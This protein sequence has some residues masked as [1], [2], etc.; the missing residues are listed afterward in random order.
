[1]TDHKFQVTERTEPT[2][3]IEGKE[4]RSCEV[5][6]ERQIK[7]LPA[8]GHQFSKWV[9]S[10]H[11]TC[12]EN[13]EEQRKCLRCGETETKVIPKTG[14]SFEE[15]IAESDGTYKSYCKNC[16]ET[17]TRESVSV[18]TDFMSKDV[19]KGAVYPMTKVFK[20]GFDYY[21]SYFTSQTT[22]VQ[23]L[24]KVFGLLFH[25]AWVLLA[26]CLATEKFS[27]AFSD[28][29]AIASNVVS[30]ALCPFGI[31]LLIL[32]AIESIQLKKEIGT[33][34]KPKRVR[35]SFWITSRCMLL[36]ALIMFSDVGNDMGSLYIA[37]FFVS[38][39]MLSLFFSFAP[40]AYK[41]I[42]VTKHLAVPKALF[43]WLTIA[44]SILLMAVSP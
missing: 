15:W 33:A 8:L 37:L 29:L 1:M 44:I 22:G 7:T 19:P 35:L 42:G 17:K 6:G 23:K 31:C 10:K 21:K 18:Q 2:C 13:G 28:G 4:V 11:A 27:V 39:G 5:C 9:E 34:K 30:V 40:R 24:Q 41:K 26:I 38:W 43:V 32:T 20:N 12:T 14:H 3:K 16:G 25:F 36:L